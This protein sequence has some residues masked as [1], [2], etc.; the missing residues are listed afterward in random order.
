MG[1]F[2][3]VIVDVL[4]IP[5]LVQAVAGE[6]RADD[7]PEQ[8]PC[9]VA[10]VPGRAQFDGVEGGVQLVHAQGYVVSAVTAQAVEGDAQGQEAVVDDCPVFSASVAYCHQGVC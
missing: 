8:V 10:Y 5:V 1:F 7:A 4:W 6:R 9:G 2:Q 3:G